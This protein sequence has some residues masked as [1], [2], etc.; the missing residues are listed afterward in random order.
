MDAMN[1]KGKANV[2]DDVRIIIFQCQRRL[3]RARVR[4][5]QVDWK[6]KQ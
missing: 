3:A 1:A 2:R 6:T 4:K 5:F